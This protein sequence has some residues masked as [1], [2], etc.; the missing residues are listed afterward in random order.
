VVGTFRHCYSACCSALCCQCVLQAAAGS[1]AVR[2]QFFSI[3]TNHCSLWHSSKHQ[4]KTRPVLTTARSPTNQCRLHPTKRDQGFSS[5]HWHYFLRR[6]LSLH[7]TLIL[8]AS[9]PTFPTQFRIF[10]RAR[11]T[12][13]PT[14]WPYR[15]TYI[16]THS[17]RL[18][19]RYRKEDG[20]GDLCRFGYARPERRS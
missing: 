20:K 14:T 3:N 9:R 13:D 19:R 5:T 16:N 15:M 2:N 18:Q 12:V 1:S 10:H 6:Q 17:S 7:P 11:R 4:G 8:T